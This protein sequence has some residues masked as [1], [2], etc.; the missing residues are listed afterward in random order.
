[1]RPS[2]AVLAERAMFMEQG[3]EHNTGDEKKRV[4]LCEGSSSFSSWL[5]LESPRERLSVC[6]CESISREV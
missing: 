2:T 3:G 6:V 1:M 4:I 5:S